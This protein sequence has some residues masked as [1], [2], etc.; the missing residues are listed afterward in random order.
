MNSQTIQIN[1]TSYHC[2]EIPHPG[3]PK[4]LMLHGMMVESHCFDKLADHL[5]NDYHLFLLDLKGHG[6]SSNGTSY[7][8][9]YANEV[10]AA[11]LLALHQQLIQDACYLVGY[12]LGGQYAIKFAGTHPALVKGLVL[13]DSA[14]AVG[15]FGG[16]AILYAILTTPRGFRDKAHVYRHYE[17]RFAGLGDYMFNHCLVTD[18][19]GR[20]CIRYDRKNLMPTS[21]AGGRARENDLWEACRH[22]PAPTLVLRA[23]KSSVISDGLARR[24]KLL[25][26]QAEVVL[27]PGMDH[28]LVFTHP[29]AVFEQ[30]QAFI[31]KTAN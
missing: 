15:F 20:L 17:R 22:I 24:L 6:K 8:E 23:E 14:P 10:I 3:K 12:S 11:D 1:G 9:S 18:A 13:I 2:Y 29:Q 7:A 28:S 25:I 26:P 27:M 5:K 21:A 31:R 30:I 19:Q 4:M 16:L